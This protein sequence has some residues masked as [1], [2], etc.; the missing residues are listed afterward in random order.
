VKKLRTNSF[1]ENVTELKQSLGVKTKVLKEKETLANDKLQQ[2]VA[3]QNVAEKRKVE[4]KKMSVEVKEQKI[5]IDT[6]KDEAQ[7]D[8]D[9]AEPAL[10]VGA[11][12]R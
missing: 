9:E 10:L 12:K 5:Q 11:W 8:L 7:R 2:M 1:I 4:A 3:D 6:R